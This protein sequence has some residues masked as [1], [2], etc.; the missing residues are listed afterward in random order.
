MQCGTRTT[1]T[2][3]ICPEDILAVSFASDVKPIICISDLHNSGN[4]VT[5]LLIEHSVKHVKLIYLYNR[6]GIR[7][8]DLKGFLDVTQDHEGLSLYKHIK[9]PFLS[10]RTLSPLWSEKFCEQCPTFISQDGK[11]SFMFWT[12][13]P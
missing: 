8:Q 12:N 1:A 5:V 10:V 3:T 6:K 7:L 9:M 2:K 13:T 4:P 11:L